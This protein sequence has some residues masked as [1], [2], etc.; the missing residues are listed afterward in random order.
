MADVAFT[1]SLSGFDQVQSGFRGIQTSL[2]RM[3]AVARRSGTGLVK[4][5]EAVSNSGNALGSIA[6]RVS[7]VGRSLGLVAA[8]SSKSGGLISS[9]M[10]TSAASI[11]KMVL[12][13]SNLALALIPLTFVFGGLFK[14][15]TAILVPFGEFVAL[16]ATGKLL[17]ALK[18]ATSRFALM[19][20]AVALVAVGVAQVTGT[21]DPFIEKVSKLNIFG[22]VAD[23]LEALGG[24]MEKVEKDV[25]ELE[26]VWA[27]HTTTLLTVEGTYAQLQQKIQETAEST[28]QSLLE[29]TTPLQTLQANIAR[30]DELWAQ[31]SISAQQYAQVLVQSAATAIQPWLQVADTIAQALGVM[32]E[33][34]KAVAI[35][36][37]VISTAQAIAKTIAEYGFT[38]IGIAMSAAA[39][40]LG[41]AQ[42]AKISST[43]VGG[44]QM[45]G[46]IP[47]SGTGD[48]VRALLEP[49]EFV[50]NR[51]AA[52][53]NMGLLQDINDSSPR[54]QMGGRVGGAGAGGFGRFGGTTIVFQ[55]TNVL[56]DISFTRMTRKVTREQERSERRRHGKSR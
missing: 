37:A 3:Q 31:G 10:S 16:I 38:P 11:G 35:A 47:G 45:G 42:I 23:A 15:V 1:V 40:A 22:N 33:D 27:A 19:A 28:V 36:Q 2:T 51:R 55:G 12:G 48:K 25:S 9:S 24:G 21:L 39:A 52:E 13:A 17:G 26:D 6:G 56:D 32:F 43:S 49:G 8:S 14:V 4:F 53:A 44:K 20:T 41:A 46:L 50:V 18:L 29:T 54:F 7:D 34:N 30:L 5:G